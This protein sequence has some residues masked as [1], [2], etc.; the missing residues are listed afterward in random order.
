MENDSN[1]N[2][3]N[4]LIA[5]V[6]TFGSISIAVISWLTTG[7]HPL[8]MWAV[9]IVTSFLIFAIIVFLFKPAKYLHSKWTG[10]RKSLKLAE[11]Y[12]PEIKNCLLKMLR[13]IDTRRGDNVIGSVF[14]LQAKGFNLFDVGEVNRISSLVAITLERIKISN[15][16]DLENLIRMT[17]NLVFQYNDLCLSIQNNLEKLRIEATK[18]IK[19]TARTHCRRFGKNGK[20][21]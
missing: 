5:T 2:Q 15:F 8:P 1:N 19:H 9:V 11:K 3:G 6:L 12:H 4:S 13:E 20:S 10:R 7:S 17:E 21:E 16:R 18:D 14:D